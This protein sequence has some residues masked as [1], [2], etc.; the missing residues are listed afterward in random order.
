MQTDNSHFENQTHQRENSSQ[1]VTT[2]SLFPVYGFVWNVLPY[3]RSTRWFWFVVACCDWM[4]QSTILLPSS[5]HLHK[6]TTIPITWS[7]DLAE[8]PENIE[9]NLLMEMMVISL[10]FPPIL[11]E[12]RQPPQN[13]R[14]FVKYISGEWR[15]LF[16]NTIILCCC[17]LLI[18]TLSNQP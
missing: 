6:S 5:I 7:I 8:K 11:L 10:Q 4:C 13:H 12:I 18:L 15:S 2:I 16:G 9:I 1:I 14:P 3:D 17:R